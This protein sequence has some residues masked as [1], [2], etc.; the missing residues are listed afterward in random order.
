MDF[1]VMEARYVSGYTVWLRFRDGTAGQIDL[2][3]VI[4]EDGEVFRPLKDVE[5]F[6]QFS[7]DPECDTLSWPNG[8]DLAPEF[9]H[10]GVKA[11]A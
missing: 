7:V 2:W 9:L 5:F 3:P 4:A 6:R 8:A 1:D 10:D 11:A